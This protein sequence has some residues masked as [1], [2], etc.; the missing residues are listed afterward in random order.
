MFLHVSKRLTLFLPGLKVVLPHSIADDSCFQSFDASLD[1]SFKHE[2]WSR[3]VPLKVVAFE[4][5]F[6]PEVV[7]F[8]LA[9]QASSSLCCPKWVD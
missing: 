4:S 1:F 6:L 8:P 3:S 5:R 7:C 9:P 2:F